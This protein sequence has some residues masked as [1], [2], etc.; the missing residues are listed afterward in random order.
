MSLPMK[1]KAEF[2]VEATTKWEA[3]AMAASEFYDSDITADQFE[4]ADTTDR[5]NGDTWWADYIHDTYTDFDDA[6]GE[7]EF[8]SVGGWLIAEP[9]NI[10]NVWRVYHF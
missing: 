7:I 1:P 3:L 8:S 5:D 4:K 2:I 6:N 10:K 9:L